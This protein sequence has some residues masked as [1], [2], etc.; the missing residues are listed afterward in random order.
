MVYDQLILQESSNAA[1][2]P[3]AA[4]AMLA[5]KALEAGIERFV[6]ADALQLWTSRVEFA[7][8]PLPEL[9]AALAELCRGLRGFAELKAAANDLLPLLEQKVDARRLR[10]TAPVS[11][12]L[13][14]GRLTKVHYETGKPPWIASR[15]QDFF[16]MNETP[17]LGPDRIPVVAHLLAPNHRAVQTTADLAGFWQR[18]Y[19]QVRR[20]LMRRYPR[21]QWPE[22]H[23]S[24]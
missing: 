4:A 2:E 24:A 1:P 19:P 14:N 10:E 17:R 8:L 15:L 13:Q 23:G 7:G 21:H 5:E 6:D 11:V 9:P 16:G 22:S 20:E 18:L 3:E 12:R